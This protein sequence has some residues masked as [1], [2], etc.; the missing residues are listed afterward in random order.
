MHY[1]LYL[2]YYTNDWRGKE[3]AETNKQKKE[4]NHWKHWTCYESY[5][6]A[7]NRME[8]NISSMKKELLVNE[9]KYAITHDVKIFHLYVLFECL[10][11]RIIK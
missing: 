11:E 9:K 5:S 1:T 4:D 8:I 7:I 3:M 6:N 10:S 2:Y